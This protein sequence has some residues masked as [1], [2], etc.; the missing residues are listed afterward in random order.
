M[1]APGVAV[2]LVLGASPLDLDQVLLDEEALYL[3]HLATA[4][5]PA[6]GGLSS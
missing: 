1:E 2:S 3:C 4:P 5:H 6:R